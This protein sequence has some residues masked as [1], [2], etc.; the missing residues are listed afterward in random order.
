[1]LEAPQGGT[2]KDNHVQDPVLTPKNTG[3]VIT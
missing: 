2:S 1:M 3:K